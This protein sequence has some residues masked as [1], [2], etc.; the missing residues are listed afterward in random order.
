LEILLALLTPLKLLKTFELRAN[1]T[2]W[3]GL[4]NCVVK[5]FEKWHQMEKMDPALL[6]AYT[7]G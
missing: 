1:T 3:F 4:S 6:R 2:V 5:N 7:Y